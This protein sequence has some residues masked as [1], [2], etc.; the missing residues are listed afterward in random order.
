MYS[1]SVNPMAA[2]AL[3]LPDE[4]AM[5]QRI[6]ATR[7]GVHYPKG[8]DAGWREVGRLATAHGV[9]VDYLC[10]GLTS[11]V[12]TPE[13]R[14]QVDELLVAARAAADLGAHTVY[15]TSGRSGRLPWRVA[16]ERAANLL[17]PVARQARDL[18]VTL[19]LENTMSIRADLGFTHSLR[20]T[21]ELA[22]LAGTGLCA[23]LYCCWQEANLL[24]T[25]RAN[26]DL[27]RLV[28]VSDFRVGTM[29][30]PNRWP[31]GDGDIPLDQ[32]LTG[33]R[34]L[35]YQ[36][37]VD[38]ELLGPAIDAEGPESALRRG[39]HWLRSHPTR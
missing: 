16:A 4:F 25:L 26:L 17:G 21:A 24:D 30:M 9:T 32:L 10:L 6:G 5:Y 19:T 38:L 14:S 23:D 33:V 34:E 20:D 8:R 1:I 31:P 2:L 22:R 11:I 28:Q 3:P 27:V 13:Y 39:L 15:C 18:G 36:G 7:V 12:D 35:D 37:L 29:T